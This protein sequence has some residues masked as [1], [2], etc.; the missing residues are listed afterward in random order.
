MQLKLAPCFSEPLPQLVEEADE[1]AGFVNST[2]A[3]HPFMSQSQALKPLVH[4]IGKKNLEN[5]KA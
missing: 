3:M 1:V 5:R 2:L 4:T